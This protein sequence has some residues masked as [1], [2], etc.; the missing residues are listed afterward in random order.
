[1]SPTNGIVL[2]VSVLLWLLALIL[3]VS[4]AVNLRRRLRQ[5]HAELWS[6]IDPDGSKGLLAL[7]QAPAFHEV[8][9][10]HCA[11]LDDP[12]LARWRII[13][14][15]AVPLAVVATCGMF[16]AVLLVAWPGVFGR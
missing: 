7:L 5:H 13:Y 9:R 15:W 10:K 12:A 3:Y 11:S 6:P 1:M 14:V 4:S 16:A 2:G 8:V